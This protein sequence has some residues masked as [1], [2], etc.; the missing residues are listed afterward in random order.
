MNALLSFVLF[1]FL[2]LLCPTCVNTKAEGEVA[3]PDRIS[4]DLGGKSAEASAV[5]ELSS[6]LP[7]GNSSLNIDQ[8][9]RVKELPPRI[10]N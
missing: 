2:L 3:V 9:T 1:A 5:D 6:L 4:S 10:K 7:H 8:A